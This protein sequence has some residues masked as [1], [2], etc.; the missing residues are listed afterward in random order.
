MASKKRANGEWRDCLIAASQATTD[1]CIV[2][3][4]W[5]TRP[6]H[7]IGGK[8]MNASRAVW[9]FAHGDPGDAQVLH[10]CHRGDEGC[11]NIRHLY[12][13]DNAQ[14]RRD[15]ILAGRH[16]YGV[17][18]RGEKQGLAKL[19]E[20]AVREI[21]ERAARGEQFISIAAAFGVSDVNV[22]LIVRRRTW[23]HVD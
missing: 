10:T 20:R 8:Q 17:R 21:R 12:L 2:P 23:A 14:N 16:S 1:D 9:T 22:G 7:N 6:T 15:M 13:G 18:P 4:G 3:S 5:R 11:I 19:T